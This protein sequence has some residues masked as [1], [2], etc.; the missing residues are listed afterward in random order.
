MDATVRLWSAVSFAALGLL[1]GHSS[2]VNKCVFSQDGSFLVSV[3]DDC[4]ING[5]PFDCIHVVQSIYFIFF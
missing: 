2:T 3:A 1:S 5:A 4:K